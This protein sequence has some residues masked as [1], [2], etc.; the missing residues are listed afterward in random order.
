MLSNDVLAV[1]L[2]L[3]CPGA[4]QGSREGA[5]STAQ[6]KQ[7]SEEGEAAAAG[8]SLGRGGVGDAYGMSH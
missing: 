1:M 3:C 4:G 2:E 8:G 7:G 5:Y 6:G